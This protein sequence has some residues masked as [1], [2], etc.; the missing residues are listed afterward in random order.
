MPH[1]AD[2]SGPNGLAG[3]AQ[4]GVFRGRLEEKKDKGFRLG[5]RVYTLEG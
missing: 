5:F 1:V 4:G 2:L 3:P